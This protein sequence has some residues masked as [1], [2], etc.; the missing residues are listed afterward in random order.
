[1]IEDVVS[2]KL[3][4]QC[5]FCSAVCPKNAIVMAEDAW[6]N[7]Y[8]RVKESRCNRC[9]L[10]LDI[11]SGRQ[12]S[13]GGRAPDSGGG[14]GSGTPLG[15]F[16]SLWSGYSTDGSLRHRASSGGAVSTVLGY[17]LKTGAVD[18]VIVVRGSSGG[19]FRGCASLVSNVEAIRRSAGSW[20]L[21]VH[22]EASVR[23]VI[24]GNEKVAVVGL[25]CHIQAWRKAA[26][27]LPALS[28]KVKHYIG[29]FCD[30]LVDSRF[31]RL[32]VRLFG[33]RPERVREITFRGGGWPGAIRVGLEGGDEKI[34]P[35]EH[36]VRKLL[37][38]MY[39]FTPR[40]C[41]LCYDALAEFADISAGD[42]WLPEYGKDKSGRNIVIIRSVRGE[43][44][45]QR[46]VGD[47]KIHLEPLAEDRLYVAQRIQIKMKKKE[48]AARY[49][50]VRLLGGR[51]PDPGTGLPDATLSGGIFGVAALLFNMIGSTR[52]FGAAAP[53]IPWMKMAAIY[54]RVLAEK[55]G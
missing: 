10:C 34:I 14:A 6:G 9:R 43:T 2:Y 16:R 28:G 32:L 45:I 53:Y 15:S 31:P 49:R 39:L 46:M 54:R 3:C 38:K 23:E 26:A 12:F 1:M 25:P 18:R 52:W 29:L 22:L 20:Y 36:A 55:K 35:Y 24:K 33:V 41:L 21:P 37:W 11:C 48:I 13:F 7:I 4:T 17:L 50:I 8:P 51:T 47:G 19:P 44:L 27:R 42:A 30:H 5:G 40:R